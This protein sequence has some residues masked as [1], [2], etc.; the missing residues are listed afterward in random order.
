M[1]DP[2]P[3][4]PLPKP[5]LILLR[6]LFLGGFHVVPYEDVHCV[7]QEEVTA[8]VMLAFLLFFVLLFLYFYVYGYWKFSREGKRT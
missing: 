1:S 6:I 3:T 2:Q 8:A 5:I 4:P 7:R